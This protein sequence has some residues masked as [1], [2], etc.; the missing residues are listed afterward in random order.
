MNENPVRYETRVKALQQ[1]SPSGYELVLERAG[2]A[3]Q[4]GKE[5]MLHGKDPY[6][7]RQYS[8]ASAESDEDLRILFRLI[9]EG[10]L[11]PQLVGWKP[12]DE[13]AF[14]GPFGSFVLRDFVRPIVFIAT[15]TGIAP[16]VCFARSHPGLG[17]TVLHGVREEAD[18]FYRELFEA[19]G[20]Y[21]PCVS[22][23]PD[24]DC[25]KGRVTELLPTLDLAED[26]HYYLCGANDMILEVRRLLLEQGIS[27][28]DIFSEAY[29]FW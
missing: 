21:H 4:A 23:A 16:A 24:T 6:D 10:A 27:D 7:D 26:A 25:F 13:V 12:G 28:D 3:F 17:M 29:Y 9:P 11:T 2:L 19:E 20:P 5:L 15:G 14:T 1:I 22:Q 18:L 8:I